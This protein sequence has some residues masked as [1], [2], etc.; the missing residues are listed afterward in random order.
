[1][2]IYVKITQEYTVLMLKSIDFSHSINEYIGE[3]LGENIFYYY[4]TPINGNETTEV[5]YNEINIL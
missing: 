3:I 4:G 5:W 2:N 1:M